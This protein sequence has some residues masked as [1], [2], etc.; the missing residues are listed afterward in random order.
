M[1]RVLLPITALALTLAIPAQTGMEDLEIF[2]DWIVIKNYAYGLLPPLR[3]SEN[4]AMMVNWAESGEVALIPSQ[5]KAGVMTLM[6]YQPGT[7]RATVVPGFEKSIPS[8]IVPLA[9]NWFVINDDRGTYLFDG[10]SLR[11]AKLDVATSMWPTEVVHQRSGKRILLRFVPT[12]FEDRKKKDGVVIEVGMQGNTF[13]VLPLKNEGRIAYSV[14]GKVIWDR[15][16]RNTKSHWVWSSTDWVEVPLQKLDDYMPVPAS[17]GVYETVE[18]ISAKDPSRPK[19]AKLKSVDAIM[20]KEPKLDGDSRW[21]MM[22]SEVIVHAPTQ[23]PPAVSPKMNSVIY[24]QN[25]LPYVRPMVKVPLDQFKKMLFEGYKQEAL[26][27]SKQVGVALIIYSSDY[28]EMY[29]DGNDLVTKVN[30]YIKNASVLSSFIYTFPGGDSSKIKDPA[31]TELGYIPGPGGR[32]V[33]YA[34]GHAKWIPD[35]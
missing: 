5:T 11:S 28:D 35:K 22:P 27:N 23:W 32:A 2:S 25:G 30:P 6:R 12:E 26:R 13:Q 18:A 16:N 21:N 4:R 3:V 29:P 7:P 14:D 8:G 1:V 19:A 15:S 20:G 24:F 34:D 31:A 33:V 9:G 10:V 17:E